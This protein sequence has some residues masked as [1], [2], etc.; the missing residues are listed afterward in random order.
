MRTTIPKLDRLSSRSDTPRATARV[1]ADELLRYRLG[2][3]LATPCGVLA[4]LLD[5]L[6][7]HVIT[8][9]REEN[10]IGVA[11]GA[12]LAGRIPVVLIQNSGFGASVNV[13]ASLVQPYAIPLILV[14]SLRG[15][16]PDTTSENLLMGKM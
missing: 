4:P 12:A 8:V 13:L 14:V 11:A 1:V 15:W 6:G 5:F 7:T 10:A 2:P 16:A 3:F 9:S